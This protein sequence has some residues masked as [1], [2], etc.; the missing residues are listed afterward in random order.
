MISKIFKRYYF[1]KPFSNNIN[2]I[3]IYNKIIESQKK[4]YINNHIINMSKN[5]NDILLYMNK[6]KIEHIG[7]E[8]NG[9]FIGYFS[10]ST[11]SRI[12]KFNRIM[13]IFVRNHFF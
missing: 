7:L 8:K 4:S 13:S 6:N 3:N 9:K 11:H 2:G 5:C 1:V 10:Y 12:D